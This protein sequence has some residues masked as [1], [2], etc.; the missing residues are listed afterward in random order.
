MADKLTE[1]QQLYKTMLASQTPEDRDSARQRYNKFIASSPQE[2]DNPLYGTD[3]FEP[4]AYIP[5]MYGD[6]KLAEPLP[7]G[8]YAD[9]SIPSPVSNLR[10]SQVQE[11]KNDPTKYVETH[12]TEL[13][14]EQSVIDRGKDF[15]ARLFD[16]TDEPDWALFGM[17]LGSIES[18]WDKA[19][20]AIVGYTDLL[21]ISQGG[22]I[23]AMPG[24]V[25][26]LS[27]D[28]LSDN[29]S[30]GQVF[31]GEMEPGSTPSPGQ[32]AVTSIGIEAARIRS[33][34]ARISDILLLNPA[35][36]P[37]ILAALKAETSPLQQTGFDLL[38]DEQRTAAFGSGFEQWGSG[39]TDF[40]LIF[41]DPAI[42]GAWGAKVART[43]LMGTNRGSR[44]GIFAEAAWDDA[45]EEVATAVGL[46]PGALKKQISDLTTIGQTAMD[47]EVA[48]QKA[49]TTVSQTPGNV[50]PTPPTGNVPSAPILT[51]IPYGTVRPKYKNP[52]SEVL[53]DA[54][55]LK[56]NGT[57]ERS[58]VQLAERPELR[59]AGA[60]APEIGALLY[61]ADNIIVAA[62]VLKVFTGSP[63]A[64]KQ[65]AALDKGMADTLYRYQRQYYGDLAANEP[66]KARIIAEGLSNDIHNISE[67]IAQNEKSLELLTLGGDTGTG[68]KR[69]EDFEL[70]N[71]TRTKLDTN[72]ALRDQLEEAYSILQGSRTRDLLDP[73]SA[74]YNPTI[75]KEIHDSY[76]KNRS[77]TSDLIQ[78][79]IQ[80]ASTEARFQFA[81][82]SNPYSRMVTKSRGRRGDAAY[83]YG[84]EKTSI[85]P[86]ARAI[87][88]SGGEV[89]HQSDGWFTKSEFPGVSRWGRNVR[90]WRWA[91][92]VTPSGYLG[93]KGVNLVNSEVEMAAAL[94]LEIYQGLG[95]KVIKPVY[96][97][98][99]SPK[100][101]NGKQ[102][103]REKI[104]GGRARRD[105]LIAKW[106]SGIND[107][108]VNNYDLFQEIEKAIIM[109]FASA[110]T[111]NPAKVQEL[112]MRGDRQRTQ[113]LDLVKDK[114]YWVDPTDGV[115]HEVPYAQ[116]S[117]ASGTYMHNFQAFENEL[118]KFSR[119]AGGLAKLQHMLE[120]P[121]HLAASAYSTFDSVWRPATLLRVSYTSRNLTENLIRAA[122]YQVS[123]APLSWPVR[124]ATNGIRNSIIKKTSE[125]AV[126]ATQR[127]IEESEYGQF[128]RQHAEANTR[129]S[130]LRIAVESADETTGEVKFYVGDLNKKQEPYTAK[131]YEAALI[132]AE[133]EVNAT[134]AALRANS[135]EFAK[136]IKNTKFGQWR[137]AQLKALDE[138]IVEDAAFNNILTELF[139]DVPKQTPEMLD[140]IFEVA[141]MSVIATL[142]RDMLLYEPAKALTEW[143][144][145][146]IGRQKRIGSG[147]SLGPGGN[148]YLNA[149]EGPYD[150][151]NRSVLSS[152]NTIK[153]GLT[154]RS[155]V[156]DN[157]FRAT[158]ITENRAVLYDPS[159]AISMKAWRA[160]MAE[161][162][163]DSSSNI[164]V[165]QLVLY[166]WDIDKVAAWMRTAE[167][168]ETYNYVRQILNR[169]SPNKKYGEI[170]TGER[171]ADIDPNTGQII[172]RE[173]GSDITLERDEFGQ[174][175]MGAPSALTLN[176][177]ALKEYI[178][179]VAYRTQEGL[180]A[181]VFR[182]LLN[183]RVEA[184]RLV[185][186]DD[187]RS[188]GDISP[189]RAGL[190]RG[191]ITESDINGALEQ[192]DPVA[193]GAL[194]AVKGDP[195]I[196]EGIDRIKDV[197]SKLVNTAFKYAAVLPEDAAARGPFYASRFKVMRN[198]LIEEY[199][200]RT[201]NAAAL[202]K[203]RIKS[204]SGRS[205]D[206]TMA[207]ET[208]R[209][210]AKELDRIY[211]MSHKRAL[212]D[213]REW[214]YTIERRTNLGKY[215]EWVSP[216][217]SAQQNSVTTIGK[218][219]WK[220][221][222]LAPATLNLWRA[223]NRLG[224]ED[225]EGNLTLPMPVEW[226]QRWLNDHP[227]IPV[228][229]GIMDPSQWLTVPKD[230]FNVMT[231]ETG[232][233]MFPRPATYIQMVSSEFMKMN[234]IPLE[235]PDILKSLFGDQGGT[236]LYAFFQDWMF[237]EQ[238]SLSSKDLS[239]DK[240]LPAYIQKIFSSKD[241]AAKEYQAEY[242]RQLITQNMRTWARERDDYATPDEINKRTTNSFFFQ[243]FGNQG[244]PTPLTPYPLLGR[245]KINTPLIVLQE[246]QQRYREADFENA[247]MNMSV[248]LGDWALPS[249]AKS[250]ELNVGGAEPY[251]PVISDIKTF[252]SLLAKAAPLIGENLDVL[253]II[254]NNRIDQSVYDGSARNWLR[255]TRIAGQSEH[256][257]E[258]QSAEEV[259]ID[260]Q[261]TAGWVMY[262][263]FMDSLDAQMFSAGVKSRESSYGFPF[264][265]S[266]KRFVANM[267][268]NPEYQGWYTDF[269]DTGGGRTK[270]AIRV[271]ELAITDPDFNRV[272]IK[273]NKTQLLANMNDYVYARRGIFDLVEK[274]GLSIND[275]SNSELKV[276]WAIIQ[277]NLINSDTRW[278]DIAR[279]YLSSEEIPIS[280]TQELGEATLPYAGTGM[281]L[282]TQDLE[283]VG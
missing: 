230:S 276:T 97:A 267:S 72:T 23:S 109:D 26:T 210:P 46:A 211:R 54:L 52:L 160:G 219:L 164:I 14:T 115:I 53:H 41:A 81:T 280:P 107:P 148:Y 203:G 165:R 16:Y 202:T 102:V 163:E 182:D 227:E 161:F 88:N 6:P 251:A 85:L 248:Q 117:L 44:N 58:A 139:G 173:F 73:T 187:G 42:V 185:T 74:T 5:K 279:R 247:N 178:R 104:F 149:F 193:R 8:R 174:P 55:E 56:A 90:I 130:F 99:G 87:T 124:A 67:E 228:V 258:V 226:V 159:D 261:K 28:E 114:G 225:D 232:L 49:T 75:A 157:L 125:R 189:Q 281:P 129:L 111:L 31:R 171:K 94:N 21:A 4:S 37:F 32:I 128:V 236:D 35:T 62:A 119:E 92:A 217:I 166:G 170:S 51:G 265:Q 212:A 176:P 162:I 145:S 245:P 105:E 252:D 7:S 282:R 240:A 110:Y 177:E 233:G 235:T 79:E 269:Q 197:W 255:A 231:P 215:G 277:Q 13:N 135:E 221:P 273:S 200:V 63:R 264:K 249:A 270:A 11:F 195:I 30:V 175:V 65:V 17:P 15:L 20:R 103:M 133:D 140:E 69:A 244:I 254:V 77:V 68:L 190:N 70:Y 61:A 27:Y 172:H 86:H 83:Q 214:L 95:I 209:I 237:G 204:H 207:H 205:Q 106:V 112:F 180:Q 25:P 40:G 191:E 150:A 179:D 123:L 84:V 43:G 80:A 183:R 64:L 71:N 76:I 93:L 121:T 213:T 143:R 1:S 274:S 256:W 154:V 36:G 2:T 229:G 147:T 199:L 10:A 186:S 127:V 268:T 18:V 113:I 275:P 184:K 220:E 188:I 223:P 272:M 156:S 59:S 29:K 192:M 253:G 101:R 57:K 181:P 120:I 206:E 33:G 246:I 48:A 283:R 78:K 108:K 116:T 278:A 222:W 146:S 234:I 167:G 142:K 38:N 218:L 271:L 136:S 242:Q 24:G 158:R 198:A 194:G 60:L 201:G 216:F 141:R 263:R 134:E 137:A 262:N 45:A 50:I 266:Y 82:R 260:S 118:K 100:M 122:A 9:P 22:V 257:T 98:D 239:Y 144:V 151:I 196:V 126:R 169:R 241:V 131:Q 3:V 259:V 243:A 96:N 138:Q 89:A 39:L 34:G 66:D 250:V 91:G 47:A 155:T 208:I 19:I 12:A 224:V 168:N 152:D 153:Q 238:G 132:K